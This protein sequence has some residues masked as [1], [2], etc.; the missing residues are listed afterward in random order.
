MGFWGAHHF[1]MRCLTAWL[2]AAVLLQT[3]TAA[4]NPTRKPASPGATTAARK[5]PAKK[6]AKKAPAK[7]AARKAPARKKPAP[8]PFIDQTAGDFIDGDDL[9]IRRAAVEALGNYPGSVV[10]VNPDTGRVL[11]VVN[12]K[13]AYTSGFIPCSTVKLVT[14]LAALSEGIVERE[15]PLSLSRRVTM[16]LTTAMA[17]SN[18]PYFAILGNKLGFERVRRYARMFGLGEKAGLDIEGEQP[19]V[20]PSEPPANGGVGLMTSF[21]TGILQ[22]PL[23]L[24]AMLSAISNG[25]TLYYL[26]YPRSQQDIDGFVPVVKRRLEI[27]PWLSD[28]KTGMRGAVEFG[29]ARRAAYGPDE[30]VLGKTGTCT[31]HRA[32][33]RLGWFGSFNEAGHNRL[34]VVV[35]LTGGQA[36]NGPVASG[37]AGSFYRQLF[38]G[39]YFADGGEPPLASLSTEPCCQ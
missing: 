7:K 10:V 19:G 14:G 17:V 2:L 6:A 23:E 26:Q 12:Q 13:L 3:A 32:S 39:N 30:P 37:V 1:E 11:T 21:G 28:L 27:E 36:I 8:L 33:T 24:A 38:A 15:T 4:S 31:D 35:M 29:T 18:N 5:A 22:T 9:Q 25:G 20:L 34:V 16:N